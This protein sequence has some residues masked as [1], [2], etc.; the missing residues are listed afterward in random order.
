MSERSRLTI[1]GDVS[2]PVALARDDIVALPDQVD[3]VGAH[4]PRRTGRAV[5][6]ATLLDRAGRGADATHV[7]FTSADGFCASVPLP[8]VLGALVVH[9]VGDGPLPDE[10]GGPFRMLIPDAAACHQ[11]VIDTCAN[12]KHLARIRLTVGPGEDSRPASAT[13]H[14]RLRDA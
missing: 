7:T 3:D 8:P 11:D 4:V 14:R 10:S 1:E 9:S 13:A 12:V 5:R 6:L 2:E